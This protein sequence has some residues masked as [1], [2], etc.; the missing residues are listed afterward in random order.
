M[1]LYI[2]IGGIALLVIGIAA[3]FFLLQDSDN[4]GPALAFFGT[5]FVI[6]T[7][8]YPVLKH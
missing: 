3:I 7:A 5:V 6:A 1:I 2:V 8:L 4:Y